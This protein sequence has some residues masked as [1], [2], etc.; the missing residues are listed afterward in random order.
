MEWLV[1]GR[2]VGWLLSACMSL[3]ACRP[4]AVADQGEEENGRVTASL[5]TGKEME[6][7]AG[8]RTEVK[9]PADSGKEGSGR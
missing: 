9:W 5:S 7:P 2:T 6:W 1:T 8:L 3:A 4:L